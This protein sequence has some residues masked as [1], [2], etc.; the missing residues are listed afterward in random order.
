MSVQQRAAAQEVAVS[1]GRPEGATPTSADSDSEGAAPEAGHPRRRGPWRRWGT[2]L[3][4]GACLA[5]LV[6]VLAHRVLSGR[7][8]W[9]GPFD[10]APPLVFVAVPVVLLALVP[11][12][13]RA[14]RWLVA[15]PA[16][17]L[18]AGA[19]FSGLNPATLW[20]TPPPAPADALDVVT[21]NTE[22]WDQD[23]QPG[24]ERDT[25][26]FY[27]FLRERDAD[28]YLLHEYAHVDF[29]PADIFA[30]VQ[31]IDHMQRL[32]AEFPDYDI[33]VE[34]RNITLSRYPV[35]GSDWLDSA[36]HLPPDLRDVPAPMREYPLFYQSQAMR[37]DIRVD[38]ATVSFYNAHLFQPPI[39]MLVMQS[40][41]GSTIV[42]DDRFNHE[43]RRASFEALRQD[44]ADNPHPVVLGGDLNTSPAMG[45]RRMLPDG[46]Q[47]HT[48]V[49]SSLYPRSWP[50]GNPQLWRIDWLLTTPD[51]T[52]HRYQMT[53][54]DGLSDHRLQQA[55][56]SLGGG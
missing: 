31:P 55:V 11:L 4:V 36:P 13:R 12:A 17:A 15:V 34:G 1:N 33:V 41:P 18:L 38:G 25:E 30:Q 26:D 37:T 50:V 32:R 46:L 44:V 28:V 49:L 6:F 43:M 24:Q 39:R 16:L 53:D 45:M 56:L 10:L 40:E 14:R 29:T 7:V 5:W 54:P 35:V 42:D 22:Y 51:V 21:W 47:D 23:L 8:F 19:S 48:R 20:H 3:L 27:R 2:R 9:W 52:V